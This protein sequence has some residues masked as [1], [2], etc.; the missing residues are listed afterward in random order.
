MNNAVNG[1]GHRPDFVLIDGNC[2]RGMELPHETLVKGDARSISI[3]AASVLAKVARD[4]YITE[5]GRQY[6]EYGFEKHKGYGTKAHYEAL[7]KYGPSPVHRRTFL[8]KLGKHDGEEK[9]W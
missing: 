1:L 7:Q 8:K 9:N 4:R 6:P 5:I 2:I 3:A